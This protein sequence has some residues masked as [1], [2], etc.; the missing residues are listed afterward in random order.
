MHEHKTKFNQ[1]FTNKYNSDK[2]VWFEIHST[3]MAAIR[4]EK[5]IKGWIRKKKL[6]LINEMNPAWSDLSAD[7][8]FNAFSLK[9]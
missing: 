8:D 2:L 4:R 1:G 7:W 9:G 3:P 5:Q 6:D